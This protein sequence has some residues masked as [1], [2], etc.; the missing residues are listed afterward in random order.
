MSSIND[1]VLEKFNNAITKKLIVHDKDL[2]RWALLKKKQVQL[3]EFS[4]SDLWVLC[5]KRKNR[6]ISRKIT[7]YVLIPR[8]AEN[9]SIEETTC[10]FVDFYEI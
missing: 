8:I 6:I 10:N 7:K 3:L 9:E 2:K 4:A 1:F 5:F